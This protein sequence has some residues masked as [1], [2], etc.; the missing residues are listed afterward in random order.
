[1]IK[2]KRIL[3]SCLLPLCFLMVL[4]IVNTKANTSP[5]FWSGKIGYNYIGLDWQ[6]KSSSSSKEMIL[7]WK[8]TDASGFNLYFRILNEDL[9]KISSCS[10]N[11]LG[12]TKYNL[13][14]VS[15]REYLLQGS[16]EN[17][18]D[19]PV[20]CSGDWKIN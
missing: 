10:V 3:V 18:W 11:Y 19:P 13:S 12:L 1:M 6:T 7:D 16:R 20:Y 2:K 9:N 15:G 8:H 5:E 14:T 17:M 4:S